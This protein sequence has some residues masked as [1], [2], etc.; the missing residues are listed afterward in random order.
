MQK[1]CFPKLKVWLTQLLP[2]AVCSLTGLALYSFVETTDNYFYVHS[3]W[4]VLMAT[5]IL[6]LLPRDNTL[7]CAAIKIWFCRIKR[8]GLRRNEPVDQVVSVSDNGGVLMENSSSVEG[9]WCFDTQSKLFLIY[10]IIINSSSHALTNDWH[11]YSYH[12]NFRH[13]LL[14]CLFRLLCCLL[15]AAIVVTGASKLAITS[16]R[17]IVINF[18]IIVA[19]VYSFFKSFW[20][21][22]LCR[23]H[24]HYLKV[25]AW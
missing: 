19:I 21:R 15:L 18:T 6:F 20:R 23:L 2:G 24:V 7:N 4:H 12:C 9:T 8:R 3:I 1:K 22:L 17:I 14:H 25:V 10:F 5:S 13:V 16:K 11:C